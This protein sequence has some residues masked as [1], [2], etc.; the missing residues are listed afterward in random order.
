M[1]SPLDRLATVV[2]AMAGSQRPAQ[3]RMVSEAAAVIADG[4]VLLIQ[5]GTGT[6]KSLGY[7]VPALAT[8]IDDQRT[9][10]IATATLA[11]QRQLVGHDLPA[12]LAALPDG[13]DVGFQVLKGRGNYLCRARLD[14]GGDDQDELGL[15]LPGG[16][17]ERQ[18]AAL[19]EWAETTAT[20][21]RDDYDGEVDERVWR[22]MSVT[23]RQCVGASR[24]AFAGECFAEAARARAAAADIVVTNHALLALDAMD[25]AVVVPE[26]D[27]LVIDEAHEFTTRATSAATAEL[28]VRDVERAIA[29]AGRVTDRQSLDPLQDA[30][31]GLADALAELDPRHQDLPASLVAPLAAVRDAAHL[32]L[33]TL[34]RDDSID[35][36]Q[37]H[38]ASVALEDIHDTAGRLLAASDA[39]VAWYST[40]PVPALKVAP[41]S[42]AGT[43]GGYLRQRRAVVLTSA[44][45]TLGGEFTALAGDVGLHAGQWH[46]SDV[47]SPFSYPEQGILYI[48]ADLPRPGRDGLPPVVLE[49]I[50]DLIDAAGGRSMVLLSSWRAVDAVVGDLA[51]HPPPGVAVHV[52][53]RGEPVARLVDRFA[54]DETSVLVGTM[55]LFQ[56]VDVAGPACSC[57]IIDRI[58]F[59]RPDDPV[60]SARSRRVEAAGGSGFMAISVPRAALLLAQGSGRLIRTTADR[61]VVAVLDPRLATA[62]YGGYLRR[63]M[64]PFWTTTDTRV[65]LAALRRLT[66]S[67]A[68]RDAPTPGAG[69]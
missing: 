68:A 63:S 21:D 8:V 46:G 41:L 10:V 64:P 23:G 35:V 19:R 28:T 47:G 49:R 42:V 30:A 5:A 20:G 7:L 65:A 18:A 27:V 11:L 36:A 15:E 4:G 51:A 48:A 58:P 45:L 54:A 14:G 16:R 56:G 33:A 67:S 55:S 59:P 34:P 50:R 38:Q 13:A 32:V 3:Q 9:V 40:L 2:T 52:Q 39:D 17:L 6:G 66:G 62:R 43:L 24:C 25:D 22:S 57:V 12:V 53:R 1:P 69:R 60:L 61:G 31:E 26:H 37:R 29:A 44:T